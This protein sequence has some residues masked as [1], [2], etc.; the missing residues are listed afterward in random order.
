MHLAKIFNNYILQMKGTIKLF[1]CVLVTLLMTNTAS[2][3]QTQRCH[4]DEYFQELAE[5]DPSILAKKEKVKKE[6]RQY[7]ADPANQYQRRASISV[8]VVVHVMHTGQN[9]GVGVNISDAQI[10]SQIDVLNEDFTATNAD[11]SDVPAHFSSVL[12]NPQIEFCLADTDPNG[13]PTTGIDRVNMGSGASWSDNLKASTIW[14]NQSYLNIWVTNIGGGTLGYATFPGTSS[15]RDGVV[16]QYTYFGRTPQ[17]PYNSQFDLG[18]TATHEIGH[19]LGLDHIFSGGCSGASIATC[20]TSGDGIC[21]TPQPDGPNYGC[22]NNNTFQSCVQGS[23]PDMWMNYMDYSDDRCLIMFSQGQVDIMQAVLNTTR[24]GIKISDGCGTQQ[25]VLV[26]GKVVDAVSGDG[27]ADAEVVFANDFFE[28]SGTTDGNGNFTVPS[29][30][31]GTYSIYAGKW[32]YETKEYSTATVVQSGNTPV[33][34]IP[35]DKGYYDDFIFD[36]GWTASGDATSG[37][38][39]R[40]QPVGT[41]LGGTDKANP[42]KDVS[43]DFGKSCYVTGNGSTAVGA[44]DVDDGDAIL[45]SPVFDPSS[46]N[47]PMLSYYSWFYNGGGT[48]TPNDELTISISNGLVTEEIETI[49]LDSITSAWRQKEILIWD[50]IGITSNMTLILETSDASNSGHIV[51]AGLD[52]FRVYDGNP[53]VNTAVPD[54]E[55]LINHAIYPNP[56]SGL[57]TIDLELAE[58]TDMKIVVYSATGK[59][60]YETRVEDAVSEQ[61]SIDLSNQSAGIYFVQFIS[62]EGSF[63]DRLS[64]IR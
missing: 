22:P 6:I 12:G 59:Q 61:L 4:T 19:W 34:E 25:S 63:T 32:G 15:T 41:V 55:A 9:V 11:I 18:R 46:Y 43:T 28:F 21:D 38:W 1:F 39:V 27:L 56:S 31:A 23:L 49:T 10:Q 54:L 58:A 7:L 51:E 16:I 48:G 14:D 5:N 57:F 24:S 52:L 47:Q 40:G 53:P 44:D 62:N 30:R 42:D 50:Y 64:I 37:L 13:N 8:P 17:N 35:L 45:T 29:L 2:A 36:L 60:V 26:G 3:Q 33:I 20:A